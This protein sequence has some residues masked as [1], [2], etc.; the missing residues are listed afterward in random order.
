MDGEAQRWVGKHRTLVTGT[1]AALVVGVIGLVTA[2][3]LLTAANED[4]IV[5]QGKVQD[6]NTNLIAESNK[7]VEERG[8]VHEANKTLTKTNVELESERGRVNDA[9]QKLTQTVNELKAANEKIEEALAFNKMSLAQAHWKDGQVNLAND[10]LEDI[11]PRFRY[12]GWRFLKRQYEGGLFTMYGHLA[13]VTSVC[14]SPDGQRLAS[15]SS[16]KTVKVWDAKNG[17]GLLTLKGHMARVN[18]VCFSPDGQRLASASSDRTVKVW[19]GK[20]GQEAPDPQGRWIS[21]S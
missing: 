16:D 20:S 14:Y 9:N 10:V 8:R 6:A 18:C 19:D 1:A 15:A 11:E 7:V 2:T 21:G 3:A 13:A 4:L 17:T 5:E 12:G